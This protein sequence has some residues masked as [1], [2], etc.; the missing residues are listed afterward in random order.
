MCGRFTRRYTWAE[1]HNVR[2]QLRLHLSRTAHSRGK[3]HQSRSYVCRSRQTQHQ[4]PSE[5]DGLWLL[6]WHWRQR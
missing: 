1:I 6:G 4:I 5:G 2:A 3:R